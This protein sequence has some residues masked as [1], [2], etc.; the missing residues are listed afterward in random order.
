MKH[1]TPFYYDHSY[2]IARNFLI[3]IASINWLWN[4]LQK[5]ESKGKSKLRIKRLKDLYVV[6]DVELQEL[7]F[8]DDDILAFTDEDSSSDSQSD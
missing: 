8:V 3:L 6:T 7:S 4:T 2:L 1:F 5:Y